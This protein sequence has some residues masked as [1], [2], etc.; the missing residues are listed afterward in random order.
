MVSLRGA[1]ERG[2]ATLAAWPA[3]SR[4]A[5]WLGDRRLPPAILAPLVRAYARLFG[6][7]LAEAALPPEA[8]PSFGAFFT[9]TLREGV[10]PID[11]APGVVVAPADAVVASIGRLPADG[12]LEQIKGHDY[13]IEALLGSAEDAA[14]FR[15]GVYATLYLSPGMYHRVHAPVDGRIA[16]WRYL[17]GRLFP[18]NPLGVRRVLG[19]YTRNERVAL[20]IEAEARLALVLVG[21]ANVGRVSLAFADLVT[22]AGARAGRFVPE[23]PVAVRRGEEVGVFNLGSTVVLLVADPALVTPVAA[24]GRVRV[25]QALWRRA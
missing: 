5:G 3:L 10:R 16:A 25:G 1:A 8:Y 18:V 12:R 13:T 7:D 6:A 24:G 15:E 22:H 23:A 9:R 14:A 21:A 19:L 11:A 17:P 4:L 2:L 20:F